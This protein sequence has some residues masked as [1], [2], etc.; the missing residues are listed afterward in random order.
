MFEHRYK[1]GLDACLY[2]AV[3]QVAKVKPTTIETD[4]PLILDLKTAENMHTFEAFSQNNEKF[5]VV[6]LA[7]H[8]EEIAPKTEENGNNR[9]NS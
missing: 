3:T 4:T 9:E 5:P 7:G 2:K 6:N 8:F 1:K